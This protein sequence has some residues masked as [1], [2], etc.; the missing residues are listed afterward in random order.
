MKHK[1]QASADDILPPTTDVHGYALVVLKLSATTERHINNSDYIRPHFCY[2]HSMLNASTNKT[3]ILQIKMKLFLHLP[4]GAD[5]PDVYVCD[6]TVC[7]LR[8]V[9]TQTL[10]F[11]NFMEGANN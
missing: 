2:N 1:L 7:C 6:L 9:G 11:G 5:V 10:S 8:R 4:P 3:Q